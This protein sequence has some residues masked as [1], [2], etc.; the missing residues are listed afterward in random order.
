MA[1]RKLGDENVRKLFR[2]GG[3]RTIGVTLPASMIRNLRWQE[4]QQ[5]V[6]EQVGK[7]LIIKDWKK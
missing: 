7:T 6:V 3:K 5:V 1:R 2:T 4:R